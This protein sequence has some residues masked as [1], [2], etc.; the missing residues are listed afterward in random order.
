MIGIGSIKNLNTGSY[1]CTLFGEFSS[2]KVDMYMLLSTLLLEIAIGAIKKV[3]MMK[4]I[5]PKP[6]KVV[7]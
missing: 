3:F 6:Q 2:N 4:N 7:F 1:F 5:L